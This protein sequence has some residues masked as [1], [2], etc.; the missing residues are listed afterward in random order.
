MP[1]VEAFS[2]TGAR[3]IPTQDISLLSAEDVVA[4][5]RLYRAA[6]RARGTTRACAR[7][8][9]SRTETAFSRQMAVSYLMRFTLDP[10]EIAPKTLIYIDAGSNQHWRDYM[11]RAT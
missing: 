2:P 3:L 10:G 11:A 4:V 6:L 9:W 7:N 1:P 8:T 5:Y